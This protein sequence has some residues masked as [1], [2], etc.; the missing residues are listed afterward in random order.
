MVS[1]QLPV[2]AAMIILQV[3]C[4][5]PNQP[6]TIKHTADLNSRADNIAHQCCLQLQNR[7]GDKVLYP[8][9]PAY[10]DYQ[11]GPL[12]YWT[13]QEASI[14]PTCRILPACSVD[15]A[16][17]ISVLAENHCL[18]AVRGG[19]H[20]SWAGAANIQDGVTIDLSA[21]NQVDVSVDSKV[22]SIGG[23]ARWEDVYLKLDRMGLAVAGGRVAEVGVGG[24]LTGGGNSFFAAQHG[25]ACDNVHNYE[26][27]LGSGKIINANIEE[28]HDLFRALKGGTNNF[29]VVTRFDLN[30]FVQGKLWGGFIINPIETAADQFRYIEDFATASGSGIDPH[31]SVINAYI[32][33]AKGPSAIANQFTYTKP[34]PYPSI[35][36]NFTSVQP[37]ISNTL[38]VTNLTDLTIEL[39]AGTPNG[40]R[41]LFGTATFAANAPLLAHLFSLARA[42]FL[43]IQNIT[44]FQASFV[45]QPISTAITSKAALTGGNSLGLGAEHGNL[46]FSRILSVP[47][48]FASSPP[49]FT[50]SQIGLDLTLQYSL[51]K[52]DAAVLNATQTLLTQSIAY[53]RTQNLY[54]EFVYLNYALQSQD[55]IASYGPEN[56]ARLREV[57]RSYDPQ[58]VFQTLCPGG[59]KL[60]R[61]KDDKGVW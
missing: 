29:G 17:A 2:L 7:L 54:N 8:Q 49:D 41:Q 48:F 34:E 3:A 13:E 42:A 30:T 28:N 43:P 4:S 44:N 51:P 1:Y 55:P 46:V 61:E 50:P 58:G 56:V 5:Y 18:F 33:G 14:I 38:R 31:A 6:S 37:Q 22:T 60:W 26:V 57:S 10:D 23:G 24:L 19:G 39:G 11:S 12:G 36:G 21:I 20:M 45:L 59:F 27:V 16:L 9:S 15:V 35:L 47:P 32:F 53:A 52:D 25:F 40:F